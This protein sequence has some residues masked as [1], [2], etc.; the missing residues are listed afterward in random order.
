MVRIEVTSEVLTPRKPN[1]PRNQ[2]CYMHTV[3]KDGK[4]RPHPE[5]FNLPLWD[6]D[7]P[8]AEGHYAPTPAS[9]YVDKFSNAGFSLNVR[10]LAPIK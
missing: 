10:T 1:Q 6:G 3:G 9:I 8:L 2:V 4:L 5:R 7:S